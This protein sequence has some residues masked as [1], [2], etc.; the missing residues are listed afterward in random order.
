MKIAIDIVSDHFAVLVVNH[1]PYSEE[2]KIGVITKETFLSLIHSG[3]ASLSLSSMGL[4]LTWTKGDCVRSMYFHPC[5]SDRFGDR[6]VMMEFAI[7][8]DCYPAYSLV[9]N[10]VPKTVDDEIFQAYFPDDASGCLSYSD[11]W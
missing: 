10:T 1:S 8:L 6:T 4:M 3:G 5:H 9:F 7:D 11:I 2:Y